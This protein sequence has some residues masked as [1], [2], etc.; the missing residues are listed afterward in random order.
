ML[1][2][3]DLCEADG[4]ALTLLS[5]N[6]DPYLSDLRHLNLASGIVF[7]TH[8]DVLHPSIAPWTPSAPRI[9]AAHN[10]ALVSRLSTWQ[11]AAYVRWADFEEAC[12]RSTLLTM[13]RCPWLVGIILAYWKSLPT[14]A[15]DF[16][17]EHAPQ[18]RYFV[19][20]HSPRQGIWARGD[21]TVINTGSFGLPGRPLAVVIDDGQLTVWRITRRSCCYRFGQRPMRTIE[22]RTKVGT[23]TSQTCPQRRIAG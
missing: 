6:H 13:A 18:A 12:G 22:L 8:G 21:M 7:V 9:R 23:G 11:Y 1:R 19:C 5:G 16:A 15:A 17:A 20:G 2:L 10:E 14:V 3:Y 4:V